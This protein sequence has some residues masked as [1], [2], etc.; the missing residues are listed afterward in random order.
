MLSEVKR[1]NLKVDKHFLIGLAAI[2]IMIVSGP[3]IVI[4]SW[5]TLFESVFPIPYDLKTWLAVLIIMWLFR[6]YN[7]NL[8]KKE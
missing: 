1:M 6:I 5:N 8:K 7:F 2:V 3:L 4:W